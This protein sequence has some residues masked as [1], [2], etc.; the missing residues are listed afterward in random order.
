MNEVI[1]KNF[2]F[3]INFIYNFFGSLLSVAE[4]L[5]AL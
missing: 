1:F 5:G 3:P 4:V 2:C